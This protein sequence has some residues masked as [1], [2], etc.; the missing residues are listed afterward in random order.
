MKRCQWSVWM[1]PR[2]EGERVNEN[3]EE[4]VLHFVGLRGR[5][6]AKGFTAEVTLTC[7]GRKWP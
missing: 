1:L 7:L 6:V 4:A 2:Q 5:R 3:T